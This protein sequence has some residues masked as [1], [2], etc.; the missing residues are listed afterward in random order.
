MTFSKKYR[1]LTVNDLVFR[2]P[3][4]RSVVQNYAN[5]TASRHL[6]LYGPPGSGKSEAA[7]IILESRLGVGTDGARS[8]IHHGQGITVDFINNLPS[9]VGAQTFLGF[10]GHAL[11]IDEVDFLDRSAQRALRKVI[12]EGL[13]GLLICTTNN[14]HKLEEAFRDRFKK[15]HLE[16]PLV[17]DWEARAQ[18][19]M[20]QEGYPLDLR[21]VQMLLSEF[22]GSAR[23][24]LEWL[25]DSSIDLKVQHQSPGTGSKHINGLTTF[26]GNLSITQFK[27]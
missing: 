1:P 25:E 11:V 20:E 15:V 3:Q 23:D 21:Q 17:Q 6:M 10:T 2:D 7:R 22:E 18:H 13:D 19:I 26:G 4:H 9:M 14:L 24:F 8:E 5:G 27:R 12:D 16:R